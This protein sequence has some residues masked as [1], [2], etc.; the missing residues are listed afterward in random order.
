MKKVK[1]LKAIPEHCNSVRTYIMAD[2][3]AHKPEDHISSNPL[4]FGPQ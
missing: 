4:I 1:N 2:D 3:P